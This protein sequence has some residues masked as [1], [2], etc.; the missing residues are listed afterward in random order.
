MSEHHLRCVALVSSITDYLEGALDL[1]RS[2]H[3]EDHLE[4][5][6]DCRA[7]LDQFRR[8]IEIAGA[9]KT[10]DIEA[11]GH[12]TRRELLVAFRSARS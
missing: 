3:I 6:P 5:C 1:E 8:T 4:E 11:I 2:A 10:M 9:L 7:A 12:R